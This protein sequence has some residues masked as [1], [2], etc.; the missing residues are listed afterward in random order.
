MTDEGSQAAEFC[1]PEDVR[2]RS[3]ELFDAARAIVTSRFA[4]AR[5]DP[6]GSLRVT[7]IDLTDKDA[8]AIADAAQRLG[9]GG[10][11]RVE[12]ADSSALSTWERLRQDLLRLENARPRVLEEYP[13]PAPGYRR[14]PVEIQLAPGATAV[15][16]NLHAAYGTFVSLRLG[17]LSYPAQP[18]RRS[19]EQATD[20]PSL[21]PADPREMQILLDGPLSV[22]TGDIVMHGVLLRN[23]SDRTLSVSTNGNLTAAVTHPQTGMTVGGFTGAQNLPLVIFTVAP[24]ETVRIPLLVGTASY[25]PELGYSVPAASWNLTAVV[26]LGDG[27]RVLIPTLP[28]TVTQ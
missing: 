19:A 14:P 16:A 2:Q 23:L 5:V 21:E 12:R 10:W 26:Q 3:H 7:V 18:A 1:A 8:R 22:R 24:A 13:T 6:D 9:I 27:R 25:L 28:F 4:E 20:E 17:A 11:A 15:A